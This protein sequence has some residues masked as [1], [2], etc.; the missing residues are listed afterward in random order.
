MDCRLTKTAFTRQ[1]PILLSGS[2]VVKICPMFILI[3]FPGFAQLP[4]AWS[5]FL[6]TNPMLLY[7]SFG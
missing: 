4:C 1:K 3:T 5:A 2:A 6:V 7:A